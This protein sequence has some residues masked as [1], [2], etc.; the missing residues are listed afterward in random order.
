LEIAAV[1]RS[2]LEVAGDYY[3]VIPLSEG[4]TA[5]AIA[6]VSGKGAAAALL[7]AS[8]YASLRTALRVSSR[9]ETVVAGINELICRSTRPE[10]YITFFVGI[11][12]PAAS[13][14]T[15]VNAGHNTPIVVHSDGSNEL[16]ES[17]GLILGV[18]PRMLYRQGTVHLSHHELLLLYTD[19]ASEAMNADEKQFGEERMLKFLEEAG[20]RTAQEILNNL[21]AELSAYR[22][23]PSF[24]D[25]LT[26]VVVRVTDTKAEP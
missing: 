8:L 21:E 9:L 24:D 13:H 18:E 22:G 20:P 12:D 19:G 23:L 3:D 14:L 26:L 25:D 17:G 2:C 4:R 7:M 1:C 6:D 10:Q 16:L 5:I 11:Y 15:Y